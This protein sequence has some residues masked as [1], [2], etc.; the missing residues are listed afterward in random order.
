MKDAG[1]GL[2]WG[3]EEQYVRRGRKKDREEKR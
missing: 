3:S 1:M 2:W